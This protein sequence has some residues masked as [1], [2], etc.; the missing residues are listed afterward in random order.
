MKGM[1]LTIPRGGI[2]TLLGPSGCGKTTTLRIIAGLEEPDEG[3]VLFDGVDV[4]RL[5]PDKRGI[6]MVFQDLALFP[7]M[8][9]YENIAFGLRVRRLP[10]DEVR[11]RVREV[12]EMVNLD[13][14]EYSGRKPS[15]L[16]GGQQQRV[17]LARALVVEPRIL[18]LDEPFS[19]LDYKIKQR[20]LGELRRLHRRMGV[21]TVYVTHDQNEAMS[22]SDKIVI[23]NEGRVI[24]EGRPEEVYENPVN[25]FV[26]TFYGDSNVIEGEKI[27]VPGGLVAVRPEKVLLNPGDGVDVLLEG[28]VEDIVFQG[29]L[30]RIDVRVN[31]SVIRVLKSRDRG[32]V[33]PGERVRIGWRRMDA[34]VRRE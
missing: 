21:T 9:V 25:T 15:Q 11:R 23:M 4:T 33:R 28:V 6:G 22:I 16:S 3:R 19:H 2:T 32:G 30:L 24:Q 20:L 13:P 17:A 5:P 7:H 8:T 1:N 14:S 27:G 26:A 18:L 10:E 29:P 12:L 34:R 31:G